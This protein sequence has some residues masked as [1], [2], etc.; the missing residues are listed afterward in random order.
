MVAD[1]R[2]ALPWIA[3]L[4]LLVLI[5]SEMR[6]LLKAS[7][8][9][10]ILSYLEVTQIRQGVSPRLRTRQSSRICTDSPGRSLEGS[11]STPLSVSFTPSIRV[12]DAALASD[13]A[14]GAPSCAALPS[15]LST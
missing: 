10:D 11:N 12:A 14:P 2:S 6:L 3:Y 7:A 5:F 1:A 9:S 15:G 8:K 13:C 4:N